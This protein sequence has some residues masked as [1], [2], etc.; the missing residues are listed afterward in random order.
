M[1]LLVRR[2][3]AE[4]FGDLLV[5]FTLRDRREVRV[6]IGRLRLASERSLQVFLS[7]GSGIFGHVESPFLDFQPWAHR[8]WRERSGSLSAD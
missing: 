8:P 5:A 6:F 1:I 4:D 7:L 3:L 2:S